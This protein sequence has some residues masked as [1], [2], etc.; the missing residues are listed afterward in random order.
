VQFG[1]A[2]AMTI[3]VLKGLEPGGQVI[4]SDLSHWENVD[5]LRLN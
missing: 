2:S 3:E 4:I 1:R 5:K